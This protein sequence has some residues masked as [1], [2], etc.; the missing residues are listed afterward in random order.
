MRIRDLQVEEREEEDEEEDCLDSGILDVFRDE[1]FGRLYFSVMQNGFL[2][3]LQTRTIQKLDIVV[4][5]LDG[6]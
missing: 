6:S 4:F 5:N 3:L 2:R 1:I